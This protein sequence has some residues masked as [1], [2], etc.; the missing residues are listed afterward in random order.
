MTNNSTLVKEE[1]IL[2]A[3]YGKCISVDLT[4]SDDIEIKDA[5]ENIEL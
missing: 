4:R 5:S 3:D 2:E 1:F